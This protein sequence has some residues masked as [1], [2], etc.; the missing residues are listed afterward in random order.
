MFIVVV[1]DKGNAHLISTAAALLGVIFFFFTVVTV[2]TVAE[3]CHVN[4]DLRVGILEFLHVFVEW[5][6]I[7]L[8]LVPVVS[9]TVLA[10]LLHS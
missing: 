10:L 9:I 4:C 7:H 2:I 3:I 8:A 6:L 1:V 5:N